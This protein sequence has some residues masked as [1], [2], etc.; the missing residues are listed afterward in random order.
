M[1]EIPPGRF[2]MG[3]PATEA[4]WSRYKGEEEPRHLVRIDYRLAMGPNPVSVDDFA[5]FIADTGHDMGDNAQVWADGKWED[6]KG[7][8]WLNPGFAQAG[9]H[10]VTCVSW[11]DANAYLDWLNQRL[12]LTGGAGAYRLPSEAEWEYACRAGTQTPFSFGASISTDQANYDGN[13][14][15]GE[16][17]VSGIYRKGTTGA[18]AFPPNAFRL[19]DMHGNVWEWC[20]D[21][22]HESYVGAPA[23][24][25]AWTNGDTS[26]RVVR[27]GSWYSSPRDLRSAMRVWLTPDGRSSDLGFRLAR[28]LLDPAS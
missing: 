10:P 5:E 25:S 28:T 26:R 19:H 18:A 21:A 16:G 2:F 6:K 24:G 17:I 12:S 27:G 13:F 1:V 20:E 14:A 22:W 23:D 4:R 9:D 3:S 8:G 11:N 7:Y 15:Y